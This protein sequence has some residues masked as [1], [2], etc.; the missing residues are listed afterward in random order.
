ML[1]EGLDDVE[2]SLDARENA[3]APP[4]EKEKDKGRCSLLDSIAEVERGINARGEEAERIRGGGEESTQITSNGCT[5]SIARSEAD[6]HEGFARGGSDGECG[7]SGWDR[8]GEVLR[9]RGGG[10]EGC[11]AEP[12]VIVI[13]D[14]D[15]E[16]VG[17]MAVDDAGERNA[18]TKIGQ[19]EGQAEERGQGAGGERERRGEIVEV[20]SSAVDSREGTSVKGARGG[21]G[22]SKGGTSGRG[23]G[24]GQGTPVWTPI[25]DGQIATTRVPGQTMGLHATRMTGVMSECALQRPVGCRTPERA[26]SISPPFAI[27]SGNPSNGTPFHSVPA[28]AFTGTKG[29]SSR[30][31]Q[32]GAPLAHSG[33]RFIVPRVARK[34]CQTPNDLRQRRLET[35]PARLAPVPPDSSPETPKGQPFGGEERVRPPIGKPGTPN[36]QP[37]S[38]GEMVPHASNKDKAVSHRVE[39]QVPLASS[40]DA[41]DDS[42]GTAGGHKPKEHAE[43][44]TAGKRL[45]Q[46]SLLRRRIMVSARKSFQRHVPLGVPVEEADRMTSSGE[47]RESQEASDREV[48]SGE[49]REK[50]GSR[51]RGK[52]ARKM[53]QWWSESAKGH[54]G[55]KGTS[56]ETEEESE[57]DDGLR[58]ANAARN[59]AQRKGKTPRAPANEETEPLFHSDPMRVLSELP[60]DLQMR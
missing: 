47:S 11:P 34:S 59:S 14:D 42:R 19:G 3:E 38:K 10:G 4:Q 43:P 18:G 16:E 24:E 31:L 25:R 32:K 1:W 27:P 51:T 53:S 37:A 57:T 8:E 58:N 22:G 7:C 55:E 35:I 48:G 36:G 40:R 45:R 21:E 2:M 56:E 44:G 52:V 33:P 41:K 26:P 60:R 46:P 54:A 29:A 49:A 39:Q 23:K 30:A 15:E 28:V 20:E 17:R 9:M 5:T 50:I 13:S 6:S 12:L